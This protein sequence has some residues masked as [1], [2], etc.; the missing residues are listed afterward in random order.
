MGRITNIKRCNLRE[1]GRRTLEHL[2]WNCEETKKGVLRTEVILSR[3]RNVRVEEWLG[4]I[5]RKRKKFSYKIKGKKEIKV[6]VGWE[7]RN[8]LDKI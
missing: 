6:W 5:E 2:V 3:K 7:E 4:K 8:L 1:I